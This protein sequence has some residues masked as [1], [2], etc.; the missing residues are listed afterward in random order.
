MNPLVVLVIA[1]VGISGG[2]VF[3]A[4]EN[5]G[6]VVSDLPQFD[7]T[8]T[9][10]VVMG[11]GGSASLPSPIVEP[12]VSVENV[13]VCGGDYSSSS[14][15]FADLP[16]S[17][18]YVYWEVDNGV[19]CCHSFGCDYDLFKAFCG[20]PYAGFKLYDIALD[21]KFFDWS[22]VTLDNYD[23]NYTCSPSLVWNYFS[24]NDVSVGEHTVTIRQKDCRE[25]VDEVN[26]SFMLLELDGLFYVGGV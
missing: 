11:G 7:S 2:V 12:V 5:S 10:P 26:V 6:D 15:Q 24:Y 8:S 19:G 4:T 25:V 22:S 23:Y 16:D 3:L 9:R 1:M 14:C 21:G 20:T 18:I 13:L 17:N